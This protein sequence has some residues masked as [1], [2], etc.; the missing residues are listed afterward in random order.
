MLALRDLVDWMARMASGANALLK[1]GFQAQDLIGVIG[2]VWGGIFGGF[3]GLADRILV[4]A[5]T[6]DIEGFGQKIGAAIGYGVGRLAA[7]LLQP[8]T[9]LAVV[10]LV[11]AGFIAATRLLV[12]LVMG[13]VRGIADGVAAQWAPL[14]MAISN[15]VDNIVS[16]IR[17]IWDGIKYKIA[18]PLASQAEIGAAMGTAGP[19]L[20]AAEAQPMS[21]SN[22][23]TIKPAGA[24]TATQNN[25]ITVNGAQD[26]GGFAER[27]QAQLDKQ[28]GKF[29]QMQLGPT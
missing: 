16:A 22:L 17:R 27:V 9:W 6:L 18:N 21:L 25:N 3:S 19:I 7:F 11:V 12:G 10:R 8:T 5:F 26:P 1:G 24:S 23:A 14:S 2:D 4:L 13:A 20:P 29:K 15:L 28:Y